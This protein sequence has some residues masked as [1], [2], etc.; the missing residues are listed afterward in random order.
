MLFALN[1]CKECCRNTQQ[2]WG[3]LYHGRFHR[4]HGSWPELVKE[5]YPMQWGKRGRSDISKGIETWICMMN[6]KIF[7]SLFVPV[8]SG[9]GTVLAHQLNNKWT[10][11]G[12]DRGS[13]EPLNTT[14]S[15]A[16][17]GHWVKASSIPDDSS[18][19]F[20]CW[21][22]ET[23]FILLGQALYSRAQLLFVEGNSGKDQPKK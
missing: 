5:E 4:G 10:D 12:P 23:A 6:L 2:P 20:F 9:S 1:K 17:L 7:N 22:K 14:V 21:V 18:L 13:Q 16:W 19:L 15:A 11:T 8:V 3:V